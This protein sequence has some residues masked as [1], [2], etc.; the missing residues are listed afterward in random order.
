[1]SWPRRTRVSLLHCEN[2]RRRRGGSLLPGTCE[3]SHNN[4]STPRLFSDAHL[5]SLL[6]SLCLTLTWLLSLSP[7]RS[8]FL[9]LSHLRQQK[10][11][12][13]NVCN[14]TQYISIYI[15]ILYIYEVMQSSDLLEE[16]NEKC[17]GLLGEKFRGLSSG[18]L[19]AGTRTQNDHGKTKRSL[20]LVVIVSSLSRWSVALKLTKTR[21]ILW[22]N[23]TMR[24]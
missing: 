24:L 2:L 22:F 4:R 23:T 11:M 1:M 12:K 5:F 13:V 17:A 15:Y 19:P 18:L 16:A 10:Q 9:S 3:T 21:L 7:L 14:H 6:P 8:H 20:N